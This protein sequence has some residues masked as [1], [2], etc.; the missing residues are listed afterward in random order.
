MSNAFSVTGRLVPTLFAMAVGSASF[1]AQVQVNGRTFTIPDGFTVELVAGPP[2]VDRPIIA[3]FDEQG[4][5]YVADSSGSTDKVQKQLEEKPHRI[6]RLEDS[7][8]GGRFDKQ[9]LFAEHMMFPEGTMYFAGSVYV[10]A[11]PSIW[12][13]TDKDGDGIAEER[14]EWFQGKTLT[15]C[16]NDIHGPYLGPDGWIYWCKGAFAQQTYPRPG[17]KP[18]VTRA[19]HIFR[20]RPDGSGIEPV[21][22]GG[23][24]NPVEVVFTAGGERIFTT[25][26]LQRP[27]A[28]HRDGLIHAIYGGI[29]GKVHD[30]IDD[31]PHTSPD[32][33]PVLAHL[34][35]AASCGLVRYESGAF[36]EAYRDN[37]FSTSFNLH[38]VFRHILTPQGA[39][40][41]S[42]NEDFMTSDNLDFHPT[43]LIEDAD[44]SL[45]VIDTGGWYKL[46]CPTSQIGKPD[47]L[48]AIYRVRKID[49][50]K[51]NDPRGAALTWGTMNVDEL[52]KLLGDPRPMVR[53]RAI[54]EIAG[55]GAA[56]LPAIEKVI[57]E[58]K[59]KDARLAAVWAACR[60]AGEPARAVDRAALNDTDEIVRQA[61]LHATSVWRDAGATD[62]LI[63][64]LKETSASNR[65]AAAEALGRIGDARA[66]PA[67]LASL[68]K[69][70]DR[71]LDQSLTYAMIEIDN[72]QAVAAGLASANPAVHRA[73][74]MAMD[75]MEDTH[76]QAAQVVAE[77]SAKDQALRDTA[78]WIA[79]R[80]AE[81]ADALAQTLSGQLSDASLDQ[82]E[83]ARLG[84]Q[85]ASLSK[86][87]SIQQ[88]LASRVADAQAPVAERKL[89]MN[90]MAEAGAHDLPAS[91]M[92][93]LT[94]ALEDTNPEVASSAAS[95][96]RKLA[97]RKE[98]APQVTPQLLKLA[99]RTDLSAPARLEALA[100]IPGGVTTLNP[101]L[102]S[103]LLAQLQ[104]DQPAPQRLSAAEV[105]G[106]AQLTPPQLT[107]LAPRLKM[108]GP[109]E[110]E[111]LLSAFA[112]A[113]DAAIGAKLL[114]A[115]SEAKA[116]SSLRPESL[117]TRIK[118]FGPETQRR[119]EA[120]YARLSPD[121]G[122]QKDRLE[123]LLASLPTG[124]VRRGQ[125]VFNGAKVA[126]VSCHS[127]GYLGGKVGPDLTRIGAIRAR[128]DLLESIL[129]PSASFVQSFE[130]VIVETTDG[131]VHSGILKKNDTEEV[132][133]T[134]GPDQEVRVPRSEVRDMRPGSLSV[135]PAGLDQQLSPQ[136]MAD[137][138]TF[139]QACK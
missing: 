63:A 106:R 27:E 64:M 115:L 89:A 101:E 139:L 16:A 54:S 15:G 9:T 80:H 29:Y 4:R 33:M 99:E 125:A 116:L 56:A 60:I 51:V 130:P 105:F 86:A 12:K 3:D 59:S 134:A 44:G 39:T 22:T 28:G 5:L 85:L 108:A 123:K 14:S 42:K 23:M 90:A 8:G 47:V 73:A 18:F 91:W 2:L 129:F 131:D 113:R 127:I 32:V 128:R 114:D 57:K 107:E 38:K 66:V 34:G 10:G 84:H 19:A 1:A 97:L 109:M 83:K 103:F 30:V 102:F 95:T 74:L 46:C 26:F 76:I 78:S 70:V 100:A 61:A 121:A 132:V 53:K 112:H 117:R 58:S 81:W 13:L 68:E 119:A 124:D 111:P 77:L 122:A 93:S 55:Q 20:C 69:P 7:D 79:G 67:L 41:A 31:Q 17:K 37:L 25:T 62:R 92:A 49:A 36:G 45:L 21:M 118:N 135:M 126:C 24:D 40:F 48:G 96:L 43:H 35:P 110:I 138:V 137:L 75:Q 6:V 98:A 65:R 52:A 133:L 87:P 136:E 88:L 120:L 50:P 11:P 72:A 71:I 104:P 94:G 82:A